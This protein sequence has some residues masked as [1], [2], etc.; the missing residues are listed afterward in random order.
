[1]EAFC[2]R[3]E[4][5][6]DQEVRGIPEGASFLPTRHV[7][8][9]NLFTG[10]DSGDFTMAGGGVLVSAR[11]SFM[12]RFA[13]V[14]HESSVVG[15]ASALRPV[16]LDGFVF[17]LTLFILTR[18]CRPT[19]RTSSCASCGGGRTRGKAQCAF[20]WEVRASSGRGCPSAY[21]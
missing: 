5:A 14:Q 3:A 13:K 20:C 8:H 11:K 19:P 21:V 9:C 15:R 7:H 6:G 18:H 10:K 2:A 16:T 1:M 17:V 4:V 12:R